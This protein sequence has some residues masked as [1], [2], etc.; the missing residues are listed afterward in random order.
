[1]CSLG[2]SKTRGQLR[3]Q[4]REN[5]PNLLVREV[6]GGI[7]QG[8]DAELQATGGSFAPRFFALFIGSLTF[9]KGSL[10]GAPRS[11]KHTAG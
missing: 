10:K 4:G 8:K 11:A 2:Y 7:G 1:M 9:Q 5:R 3:C 6:S